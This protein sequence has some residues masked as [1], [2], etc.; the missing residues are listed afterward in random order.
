VSGKTAVIIGAGPAGLTAALDL[1][2]RTD[3]RPIVLEATD[4]IGGISQ[5]AHYKGN[6]MDIGGH[7]FFSKSRR[8]MEWW[9]KRLP[10]DAMAEAAGERD[11]LAATRYSDDPGTMLVRQ[12]VSR[13]YYL[14]RFFDYPLSLSPATFRNLGFR[15]TI[16]IG[17]G[18]LRARCFPIR[19]EKSLEDFFVNR[20]GRELYQTFFRDYTEKVWG[21]RCSDIRPEWGA[22]RVKGLSVSR[23]IGHALRAA[24][25]PRRGDIRQAGHETSLIE[26]FYYPKRGPGQLWEEVARQVRERGG[27]IRLQQEVIGLRTEGKRVVEVAARDPRGRTDVVAGDLFFSSMPIRDLIAR[28]DPVPPARVREIAAGL[29]YRDFIIVGLLLEKLKLRNRTRIPTDHERI[30]DNWIYVQDPGVQAGRLQIFNNWSPYL[31]ADP[32]KTWIGVEHFC[33]VGDGIWSLSDA[34]LARQAVDELHRIGVLDP[35]DVLDHTVIRM[36]KTYPAYFGTYHELHYV[37]EFTDAF[38]NLLLVGRNGQHRYNNSDHSMLTALVAVDD[39][40]AG[41]RDRSHIWQVNAEQEYHES[42]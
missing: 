20:F 21:L 38:D 9:L 22:Q 8:V 15:R 13:I 1:L 42:T 19:E 25:R 5:T 3:F 27:E 35:A 14:G 11:R 12:R 18:Y 34:D 39:L 29:V 4:A 30:P 32:D 23:A 36:E 41:I 24:V 33:S 2:E 7:R 31:S 28:M 17:L 16:R 6:L 10:L 40:L 37:R 26:R